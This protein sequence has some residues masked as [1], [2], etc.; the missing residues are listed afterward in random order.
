MLVGSKQ[1]IIIR[2]CSQEIRYKKY[3]VDILVAFP[4]I[5]TSR[6]KEEEKKVPTTLTRTQNIPSLSKESTS[7]FIIA[8][9]P[10]VEQ[11]KNLSCNLYHNKDTPWRGSEGEFVIINHGCK[12]LVIRKKFIKLQLVFHHLSTSGVSDK[13][14][15]VKE[16]RGHFT[17]KKKH[18]L[19]MT[20][21]RK[22]SVKRSVGSKFLINITSAM[23]WRTKE[24][25]SEREEQ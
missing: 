2:Y 4:L 15:S 6:E 16:H 3:I 9:K 1:N 20:R 17:L 8:P 7:F 5:P 10:A 21:A 22:S 11:N 24:R 14:V 12:L 18:S 23:E 19:Y 25:E 13:V